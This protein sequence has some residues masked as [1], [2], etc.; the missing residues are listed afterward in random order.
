MLPAQRSVATCHKALSLLAKVFV[1]Y[2]PHA[3]C[4]DVGHNV[5][6][7]LATK[8]RCYVLHNVPS[9]L[10]TKVRCYVL[11]ATVRCY[12]PQR[13]VATCYTLFPRYLP[14][15]VQCYVLLDKIRCYLPQ[16]SVAT[17]YTMFPR[18]L[19]QRSSA[20]CY[21]PRSVA[22]CHKGPLLRANCKGLRSIR[23]FPSLHLAKSH[24]LR[25]RSI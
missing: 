2:L 7:L 14:Q 9:L 15:K 13:S 17:C 6:S 11:L 1:R 21:L 16:R 24:M 22:T 23:P 12:L 5:P 4:H 25:R 8:V 20:T 19:P 3:T 18:Y 10:A